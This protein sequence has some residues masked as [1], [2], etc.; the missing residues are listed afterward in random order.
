MAM[1]VMADDETTINNVV[2]FK[3]GV[4]AKVK[5]SPSATGEISIESS[6]NIGGNDYTVWGIMPSRTIQASPR[7]RFHLL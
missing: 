3:D 7:L 1:P 5:N 2:Y 4:V 6:V